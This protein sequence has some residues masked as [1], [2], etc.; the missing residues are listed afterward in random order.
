MSKINIIGAA[1]IDILLSYVDHKEFF[2]GKY[3]VDS[4]K[5]S[6]GGDALNQSIVLNHFDYD[7]K[8]ITIL[9]NDLYGKQLL[10]Y[11]DENNIRYNPN[12]IK[13]DIETYISLVMIDNDRQRTFVGN[14]NGSVRLLDIDDIDIDDDCEFVSFGSLFISN[15]LDNDKLNTLF[16]DIKKKN[17]LL[18]VDCSTPKNNEK[19]KD[20]T[21]LQHVDYFFLNE[22][23]AKSLT[24]KED[25]EDIESVIYNS[26]VK[27]VII[28]CGDKGAFYKGKYYRLDNIDS[29]AIVDTTGA[30]DSFVA[31][32]ISGLI[33]NMDIENCLIRANKCG[34]NA[35]MY[36]GANTWINYV[37]K[38]I[39]LI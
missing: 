12:I 32:F 26:G 29:N 28:K 39:S 27:N 18:C 3:K 21:C 35:C 37:E 34:Y 11:L 36:I 8:L 7:I 25:I 30:G 33:D 19:I 6:F 20:M 22:K 5:T 10:T 13:E 38:D 1:C 4:I 9:G 14:K 2:S 31:G 16:L 24:D 17:K 15:K 23:E